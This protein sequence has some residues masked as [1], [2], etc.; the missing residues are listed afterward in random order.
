MRR[1]PLKGGAC[2]EDIDYRAS[3]GLDKSVIRALAQKLCGLRITKTSSRSGP[4]AW[5]KASNTDLAATERNRTAAARKEAKARELVITGRAHELKLEVKP[6]N[7]AAC[8]FLYWAK[9]EHSDHPATWRRPEVS[10]VSL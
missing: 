2:A 1:A 7:E 8:N 4:P 9:G 10:F 5:A 6:F 3:R